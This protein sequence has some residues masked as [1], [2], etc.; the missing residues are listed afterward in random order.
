[1]KNPLIW[2]YM[3]DHM[4]N[5]FYSYI[6]ELQDTITS[7]LEEI[8]GSAK[9]VKILETSGR[10]WRQ[11]QSNRRWFG[12]EK[13]GVNI[14]AVHGALPKSMQTYFGVKDADFYACGLSLVLHPE[15][16]WFQLCTPTGAILK[17]MIKR[18]H[19]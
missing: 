8:D 10:W 16:R 14:S 18:V 12:F 11:D 1:M 19:W 6:E 2:N 7:R 13:G 17:C 4:K 5:K 9:F 3:K 15:I